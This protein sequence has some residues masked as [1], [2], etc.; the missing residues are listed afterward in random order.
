[1]ASCLRQT[2]SHDIQMKAFSEGPLAHEKSTLLRN[3]FVAC[4]PYDNRKVVLL[5][6]EVTISDGSNSVKAKAIQG[7]VVLAGGGD[8]DQVRLVATQE[9]I[10]GDE[11]LRVTL[12]SEDASRGG[13]DRPV[14]TQGEIHG[15]EVPWA[16]L[17]STEDASHGGGVSRPLVTL[18]SKTTYDGEAPL[19]AEQKEN[20]HGME[21]G[22]FRLVLRARDENKGSKPVLLP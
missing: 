19:V 7:N 14:A 10:H 5:Y 12:R 16:A 17:R 13:Q 4:E 2:I 18:H 6:M 8:H 9:E 22:G 21:N 3:P 11:V 15:H 1:M 20:I